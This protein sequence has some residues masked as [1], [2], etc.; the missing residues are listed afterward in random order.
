MQLVIFP[1]LRTQT[2]LGILSHVL[3]ETCNSAHALIK[4]VALLQWIRY[5]LRQSATYFVT[6]ILFCPPSTPSRIPWHEP[7]QPS[8]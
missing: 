8:P 6:E 5:S 4:V 2:Y 7:S 1:A 3:K